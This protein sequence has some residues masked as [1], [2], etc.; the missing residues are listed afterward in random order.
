MTSRVTRHRI[1]LVTGGAWCALL[2]AAAGTTASAQTDRAGRGA[3]RAT[4]SA[5]DRNRQ[6]APLRVG[7]VVRP[8]TVAVGDPFL[9]VVTIEVPSDATVQWPSITDTAAAVVMRAPPRVTSVALDGLRR[10]TAEYV[11]TAWNIGPLPLGLPDA[12]V[13][14]PS[15]IRT[16]P[17]RDTRIVVRSVLPADTSLRVPKPARALFPRIVPW[18][19]A[20]WPAAAAVAALA[21]LWWAWRRRRHRVVKRATAPLDVFARAIHDFDRLQRLALADLGERGRAVALGVEILRTY[22][23]ARVPAAILAGTSA[24]LLVAIETDARVPHDRLASLLADADA[25]KFAHR[26]VSGVRARELQAEARA[27]VESVEQAEVARRNREDV[28]KQASAR[29]DRESERVARR[30]TEEDA[31]RRA[32]RPKAGAT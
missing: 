28:D 14:E 16:V 31:R 12:S 15:G 23:S 11:L 27:V 10:E 3:A 29:A 18:W 9:L 32:R 22:L 4:M 17:L 24:E 5:S 30:A 26:D 8:D 1:G 20:W 21:L 2:V 7:S 19:E 6:V 25:I 13:R